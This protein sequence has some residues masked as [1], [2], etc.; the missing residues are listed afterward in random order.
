MSR[1]RSQVSKKA[2]VALT[3][4]ALWVS[5]GFVPTPAKGPGLLTL[6]C[7]EEEWETLLGERPDI[8]RWPREN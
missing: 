1:G 6:M 7:L 8:K 3:A 5:F 2:F 4:V